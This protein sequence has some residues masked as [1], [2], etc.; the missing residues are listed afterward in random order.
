MKMNVESECVKDLTTGARMLQLIKDNRL[1][2]MIV[3][4]LLYST[5]MLEKAVSYGT[6]V[7]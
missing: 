5:G 4:I 2:A 6:G 7:C 3:T 1:E